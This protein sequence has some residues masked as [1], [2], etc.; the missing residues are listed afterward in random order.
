MDERVKK[1]VEELMPVDDAARLVEFLNRDFSLGGQVAIASIFGY[2]KTQSIDPS[3]VLA[4]C[5][6]EDKRVWSFQHP[7]IKGDPGAPGNAGTQNRQSIERIYN[8]CGIMSPI[9]Q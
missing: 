8:D 9:S 2:A 5:E 7:D 3:T 6:T 4:Q 1:Y